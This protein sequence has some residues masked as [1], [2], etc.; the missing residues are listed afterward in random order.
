MALARPLVALWPIS[1]VAP[2]LSVTHRGW[3]SD[4][5]GS[6]EPPMTTAILLD[7]AVLGGDRQV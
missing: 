6:P 3:Q 2:P 7:G 5:Q 1:S 4:A